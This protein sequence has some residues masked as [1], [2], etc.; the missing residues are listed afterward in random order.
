M[1]QFFSGLFFEKQRH[2][3]YFM[4][5]TDYFNYLYFVIVLSH[6]VVYKSFATL[7]TVA[8]QALLLLGFPR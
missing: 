8:L 3:H 7:W 1:C 2:S 5:E 6:S 4:K